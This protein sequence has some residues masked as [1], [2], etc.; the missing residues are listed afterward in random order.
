MMRKITTGALSVLLVCTTA[1][2][3][4]EVE[5]SQQAGKGSAETDVA[6]TTITIDANQLDMFVTNVGVFGYDKSNIRGKSD[7]L[8]FPNSY[9]LSDK[10]VIYDAGMWV[11]GIRG[12]DTLVT[13][14][15]YSQEFVP[16]T[17]GSD[18]D[19]PAFRVY[20]IY[21]DHLGKVAA[22][23]EVRDPDN[24]EET[25]PLTADDYTNW[26]VSQG[27]PVGTDGNPWID[28]LG[29]DQ[30]TFTVYNDGDATAHS[31]DA[32]STAPIGIEVRHTSFAFDRSDALGNVIFMKYEL[33][34]DPAAVG[35]PA[36]TLE[37]TYLSLWSDPD[38]GGAGDDYVGC[39]PALG[40]GYCYNATA[41]DKAYGEAP[42]ATGFD[43]FQGPPA[44]DGTFM[45]MTSFNKYI[46]GTDPHSY[47]DTY[48]YMQGLNIDGTPLEN[49]TTFQVPGDPVTGIGELDV[50]PAD[51]RFMMST[52]PFTLEPGDTIE[53][54]AAVMAA[55][56]SNRLNSVSLLRYIDSFAQSAFDANFVVP[57]PPATPAVTLTNLDRKV[58]LTWDGAA[59]DDS[60]SY[61]FEGY[62]VYQGET[63]SGPWT[64]IA[65]FDE[66]NGILTVFMED[67]D[68]ATG[69][70]YLQPKQFGTD[71]GVQRYIE[72]TNDA[73]TWAGNTHLVNNHPYYF[74]V[75]A[76]S[77]MQGETPNNLETSKAV[78]VANPNGGE[79]GTDW[80]TVAAPD[81]ALHAAGGSDG[82][83]LINT[84]DESSLMN[85]NYD[86]S[87]YDTTMVDPEDP[88][89]TWSETWWRINQGGNA[90][91]YGRAQSTVL[92]D[93][94]HYPDYEMHPLGMPEVDGMLVQV[95]GPPLLGAAFEWAGVDDN[96]RWLSG[97][98]W[99]GE[100]LFGGLSLG[101]HFFGST[102]APAEY[103][104]IELRITDDS[105]EWSDAAVYRRDLGYALNGIG[106]FP[107][108]AW[109]VEDPDNPRRLNICFVEM[110]DPA[111]P[112]F[113]ADDMWNP[114]DTSLGGREYLFIM[115][116]D[117]N[118]AVDYDD[119]A[120]WGPAADV[121]WA[122]W[123]KLRGNI[124]T[125]DEGIASNPGSFIFTPNYVN[126]VNDSFTFST[127]AATHTAGES[128][129]ADVRVV[130][131]PYYGFSAYETMSDV[132]VVKFTHLPATA[133]I[134]IFN[135]AGDHVKTLEKTDNG[136]NELAWNLK[137]EYGVF[138]ASGVYVYY[139][140]SPGYG[141]SFGKLAV[142]LEEERLKEY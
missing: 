28:E 141:D 130:P 133:T 124:A 67:F 35:Q 92:D 57:Q 142:M 94:Y 77:V 114:N 19:D 100:L 43:F 119:D 46:N 85:A 78:V 101:V 126:T 40:L 1:A 54:Y 73:F 72:I 138:V 59:Q 26:P 140:E 68:A 8:Y 50:D 139:V 18:P 110:D 27:A 42:P 109:D 22:G 118:G 122:W 16:G 60:G 20:K 56:G 58:T 90:R 12:G 53:I 47:T 115:N 5:R 3:A 15:E 76:Y 98:D 81:T 66:V 55:Q 113:T 80:S 136:L 123:P 71:S 17:L 96:D 25:I 129:L 120:M 36:E 41:T 14:A 127:T 65:T 52:G 83:V 62:N 38:L 116:S 84:I 95:L 128:A 134:K 39:D 13:V 24:H 51:R 125:F 44:G 23:F 106:T 6:S 93:M 10:T 69:E 9:P 105:A 117:Y 132:K 7:G 63:A 31:N 61:P 64:R 87:F 135:I 88:D 111:D 79:A 137:N 2:L 91:A 48:N 45:G 37:N 75:S 102:L 4:L 82:M 108:S 131:N 99:G 70:I 34:Y 97:V 103:H 121:Q 112:A 32:G 104:Q 29:A 86:V 30:M 33:Y 107:G 49:G 74:G 11:G 89:W 21:K